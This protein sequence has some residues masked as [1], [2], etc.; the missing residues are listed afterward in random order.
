MTQLPVTAIPIGNFIGNV[1][2]HS[3][4]Q[5][6]VGEK[7]VLLPVGDKKYLIAVGSTGLSLPW[8]PNL[9]F[10]DGLD[11][12]SVYLYDGASV[13]VI[14]AGG[15]IPSLNCIKFTLPPSAYAYL[16]FD[17]W[18]M[19]ML[20]LSGVSWWYK[21]DLSN[22]LFW[23]SADW[24]QYELY[25]DPQ[26]KWTQA[27]KTWPVIS[28]WFFAWWELRNETE[29]TKYFYIS[30]V[31]LLGGGGQVILL[32]VGGDKYNIVCLGTGAILE[33]SGHVYDSDDVPIQGELVQML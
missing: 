5:P 12:W 13:E 7:V 8:A 24:V 28:N 11:G 2:A 4:L 30:D 18:A 17:E 22:A 25:M 6:A 20:G 10:V 3:G 9:K 23:V 33:L 14:S 16:S 21:T 32:P 27:N 26:A 31:S 29:A 15:H 19:Q 1:V